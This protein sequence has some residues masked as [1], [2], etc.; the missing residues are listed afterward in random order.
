[1]IKGFEV[2]SSPL[3]R[4]S[5][6]E[7]HKL[8]VDTTNNMDKLCGRGCKKIGMTPKRNVDCHYRLDIRT[9]VAISHSRDGNWKTLHV[10]R[11]SCWM[12]WNINVVIL[13]V[14]IFHLNL[15]YSCTRV[16]MMKIRLWQCKPLLQILA[17]QIH[18]FAIYVMESVISKFKPNLW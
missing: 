4:K 10:C 7:S 1:M 3:R 2:D 14:I 8:Q 18:L 16:S 9:T 17:F 11:E 5:K 6:R 13:T 15:L 12:A